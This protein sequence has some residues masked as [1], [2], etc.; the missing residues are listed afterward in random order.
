MDSGLGI[1]PYLGPAELACFSCKDF[2]RRNKHH[3][4]WLAVSA[5]YLHILFLWSIV[6]SVFLILEVHKHLRAQSIAFLIFVLWHCFNSRLIVGWGIKYD[7]ITGEIASCSCRDLSRGNKH[8]LFWLVVSAG[9]LYILFLW[10]IV[11]SDFLPLEIQTHLRAERVG[12]LT[13][14]LWHNFNSPLI[15]G[16]GIKSYL[17]PAEIASFFCRDL[18]RHNEH[19]LF[20]LV[21]SVRY[22]Y[23]LFWWALVVSV[24]LPLE[25]HKHL[26]GES[27]AL[28]IFNLWHSFNNRWM[29]GWGI[30]PYLGRNDIESFSCQDLNQR[31]KHDLFWLV[32]SA[33]YL[34]I[35]FLWTI[36]VSYFLPF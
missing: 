4:F 26:R 12:L 29:H 7:I 21:V 35:L 2:S 33:N 11:V 9:S 20:L 5:R 8:D 28:L 23:I 19:D 25:I 16:W 27:I 36:V 34:D 17:G 10:A 1:K 6:V 15:V 32:V 22:L 30:K 13:F 18:S 31:K 24:F 14:V 3:L